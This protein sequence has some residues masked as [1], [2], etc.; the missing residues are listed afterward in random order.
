VQLRDFRALVER[1]ATEVPS[2]YLDGVVGIEVSPKAVPHPLR[3]GVYTLGE[4]I[5]VE[6][7]GETVTS[8]VVLYHGSFQALAGEQTGLDWRHEAWE[9]LLHELRHH[10]EWRARAADLEV[11]DWAAEQNYRR[12]DGDAF[13]PLFHLSGERVAEGVYRVEDDVFWDVVRRRPPAEVEITWHGRRHRVPV[14]AG[15]PPLFLHVGGLE[16]EPAG[17]VIVVVRR[18]PGLADLFRRAG[19][20]TIRHVLAQRIR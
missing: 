16:P 14:P 6:T 2:A 9:T 18:K 12:A 4:C 17:D 13:D 1:L 11:Y 3:A 8:R 5:P 7:G 15:K 10:L 19:P 20:A